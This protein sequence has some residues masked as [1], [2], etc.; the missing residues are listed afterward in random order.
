M[1][2]KVKLK[3]KVKSLAAE[4]KM[5]RFEEKKWPAESEERGELYSHRIFPLRREA[6]S[7]FLA[8]GFLRGR[9]YLQ[10][11]QPNSREPNWNRV[12]D[13]VARFGNMDKRVAAQKLAEWSAVVITENAAA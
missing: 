10:I 4:A 13:I 11:E 2:G 1:T 6:R 8:Y 3:I 5:I 7:S 12:R 9:E